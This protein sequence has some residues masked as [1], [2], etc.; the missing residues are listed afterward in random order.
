MDRPVSLQ[1]SPKVVLRHNRTEQRMI[2]PL[3]TYQRQWAK[4]FRNWQLA[5]G[6]FVARPCLTISECLAALRET[7]R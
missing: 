7:E 3:R 2:V 6:N 1:A 4:R 5:P